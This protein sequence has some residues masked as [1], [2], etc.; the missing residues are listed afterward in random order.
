MWVGV[1]G[2]LLSSKS[3]VD[4]LKL[5]VVPSRVVFAV[6]MEQHVLV[7]RF[8]PLCA[9]CRRHR[10]GLDWSSVKCASVNRATTS[11]Q[12]TL[13]RSV[14]RMCSDTAKSYCHVERTSDE[15]NLNMVV[16]LV[17]LASRS[18][19]CCVRSTG[20]ACVTEIS[21]QTT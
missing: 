3:C 10:K 12:S 11:L 6:Q 17:C 1:A 7:Q 4:N 5:G 8:R 15:R 21:D 13:S 2:V 18:F 14:F 9:S 19:G 20:R 16:A